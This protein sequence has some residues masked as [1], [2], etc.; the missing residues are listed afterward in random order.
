MRRHTKMVQSDVGAAAWKHLEKITALGHSSNQVFADWVDLALCASLS[1]TDNIRRGN[2]DLGAF[3]GPYEERY[4]EVLKPYVSN[5]ERGDRPADHFT[6]A[7]GELL[8]ETRDRKDDVLG[9]LFMA[10]VSHGENGQYFTPMPIAQMLSDIALHDRVVE[11]CVTVSD[12]GGCGSG[13]MLL[14]AGK[15][16]PNALLHGIDVDQ[17]C[18]KM[19][20]L[21][22]IMFDL[23]AEIVWGNGLTQE[24]HRTWSVRKGGYITEH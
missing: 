3:D 6:E 4:L 23:N 22:M 13:R 1:A 11:G 7:Y 18:A 12:P 15:R 19:A 8:R 16:N 24:V 9:E 5:R 2:F 14:A 21:N 10:Q 17:R 20:A